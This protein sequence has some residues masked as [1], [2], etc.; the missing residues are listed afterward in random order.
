MGA[1]D[2]ACK[3]LGQKNEL[4]GYVIRRSRDQA[5]TIFYKLIIIKK[6]L[7]SLLIF[8]IYFFNF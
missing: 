2:K 1:E 5:I 6:F 7:Y 4:I 8:L 3:I